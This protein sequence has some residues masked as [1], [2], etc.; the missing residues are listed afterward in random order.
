MVASWYVVNK[1]L[2]GSDQ[3]PSFPRRRESSLLSATYTLWTPACA[4]VTIV[5]TLL[6][7][8]WSISF[9]ADPAGG[10]GFE[11]AGRVG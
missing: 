5:E 1:L 11:I 3:K 2:T 6:T 9:K 4:G 10:S 7:M 8:H